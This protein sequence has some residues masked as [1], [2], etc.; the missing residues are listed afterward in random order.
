VRYLRRA[1]REVYRVY[2]E[3]EFL[4]DAAQELAAGRGARG[5][6][7][8]LA[9]GA[10]V[11]MGTAY[12]ASGLLASGKKQ[13]LPGRDARRRA[14]AAAGDL[15]ARVTRSRNGVGV[16]PGSVPRLV[17]ASA[18][19]RAEAGTRRDR[20]AAMRHRSAAAPRRPWREAISTGGGVERVV[21]AVEP[22][23]R[24]AQRPEF[25]FER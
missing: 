25:G 19:R 14:T 20:G 15:S 13:L 7:I 4:R 3:E 21:V 9:G 12:I 10:L 6:L 2:D 17:V 8:A 16:E 23:V 5:G 11:L 18:G 24:A 1:P 22:P